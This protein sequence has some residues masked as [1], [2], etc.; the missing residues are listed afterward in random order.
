MKKTAARQKQSRRKASNSP[1]RATLQELLKE[2]NVNASPEEIL[3]ALVEEYGVEA[4]MDLI[5]QMSG[6]VEEMSAPEADEARDVEDPAAEADASEL[7]GS[8]EALPPDLVEAFKKLLALAGRSKKPSKRRHVPDDDD[9]DDDELDRRVRALERQARR[10][11]SQSRSQQ[12]AAPNDLYPIAPRGTGSRIEVMSRFD[13]MT[14]EQMALGYILLEAN[15]PRA[16]RGRM[17]PVS[18]E[19]LKE[20]TYKTAVGIERGDSELND[21]EIR[22]NFV[23]KDGRAIRANEVMQTDDAGV[24]LEWVK[25]LQGTTMWETIRQNTPVWD[26]AI[27]LGMDNAEI[28]QGYNAETIPLEGADPSWYVAPGTTDIDT[29]SGMATPTFATSKIGTGEK[30]VNVAKLSVAMV[31]QQ[32]LVEDSIVPIV[33]EAQRKIQV[34]SAE[35]I[36]MILLRGDVTLTAN[37]NINLIDGTPASAP[38]RP[39]YTL[40]DGW[41]HLPLVVNTANARDAGATLDEDDYLLLLPLLGPEGKY[42]T[43]L[44]RVMFVVDNSTYFAS[45]RIAALKTHDV[46]TNA[47]I[48]NG[49]LTRIWGIEVLRSAQLGKANTNG[50]I[51]GTGSNNTKGR[52]LL[53]RPDQWVSR[54]KRRLQTDVTYFAYQDVT[55]VVAHM[56]WGIAYR[57]NEAAALSYNVAV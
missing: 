6:P 37:S 24:G 47:T 46:F 44:D 25:D 10:E 43:D 38:T 32:E 45:L 8:G 12:H 27:A 57:D 50:M 20:M 51:S 54:W 11:Q 28:P 36:E 1:I 19:Y 15:Q 23:R 14:P 41:A 52:I 2:E 30:A 42:A 26:R 49:V 34:T 4:I 9:D 16:L 29:S 7:Q 40:L 56:R 53:V 18:Q 21:P 17:S 22:K 48:E 3:A 5:A 33:Q 13:G 31:F 55:Q 35:Q 39:A